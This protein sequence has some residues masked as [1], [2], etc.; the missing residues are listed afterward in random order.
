[1]GQSDDKEGRGL[2]KMR[3][4]RSIALAEM[5][6]A[7]AIVSMHSRHAHMSLRVWVGGMGGEPDPLT[8]Q[9]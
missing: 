7:E 5:P 2:A 8:P 1:M 4:L 3:L 9:T 6:E